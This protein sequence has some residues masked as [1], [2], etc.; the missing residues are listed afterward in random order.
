[1]DHFTFI[2]QKID[3]VGLIALAV[4]TPFLVF[5]VRNFLLAKASKNWLKVIG[6]ITTIHKRQSGQKFRLEYEYV[7]CNHNYKNRCIFYSN[8]I[9]NSNRIAKEFDKK[10][11]KHQIVD[12]FYNPKKPKQ[13]VLEPGRIDGAFLGI[14]LLGIIMMYG[15]F[16]V[17]AP[18]LFAQFIDVLFQL[19]N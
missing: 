4:A 12:V 18:N 16:A 8:S 5:F 17:F 19:F 14:G 6:T 10:Y 7:V 2:E 15:V 11:V 13:A 1:M 3:V 9:L